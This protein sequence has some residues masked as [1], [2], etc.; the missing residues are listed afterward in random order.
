MYH[1]KSHLC[2]ATEEHLQQR[3]EE[4][5]RIQLALG[6]AVGVEVSSEEQSGCNQ[7]YNPGLQMHMW[8]YNVLC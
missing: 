3:E 6:D 5:A 4:E 1:R 7:C 8:C 2:N